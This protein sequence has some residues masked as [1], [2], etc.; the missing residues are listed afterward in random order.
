MGFQTRLLVAYNYC[1]IWANDQDCAVLTDD[2]LSKWVI[3][4][5]GVQG[6]FLSP[7]LF[8]VFIDCI[9]Q[10]CHFVG[11]MQLNESQA[12]F[13]DDFSDDILSF[14]IYGRLTAKHH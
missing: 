14:L 6:C 11:G 5:S 9:L 3:I 13:D 12:I 2:D 10:I 8:M 4:H 1:L 7:V